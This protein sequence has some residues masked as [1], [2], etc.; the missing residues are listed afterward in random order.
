[1]KHLLLI[2][3]LFAG[4]LFGHA[5]SEA[6][7]AV[8]VEKN[9][10]SKVSFLFDSKPEMTFSGADVVLAAAG[11]EVQYAMADVKQVYFAYQNPTSVGKVEGRNVAFRISGDAL[12]AD[13]LEAGTAVSVYSASG[14][15]VAGAKADAAGHAEVSLASAQKGVYLV[16]A[17]KVSYKI[18]KK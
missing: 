16:K 10:G 5:Q 11:E 13:G 15:L 7:N 8:F 4:T 6:E 12:V 17:G 1:M 9:D 14:S 3:L 2:M 18:V